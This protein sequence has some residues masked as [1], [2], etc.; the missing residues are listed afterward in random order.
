MRRNQDWNP[1]LSTLELLGTRILSACLSL[2]P[3]YGPS[4]IMNEHRHLPSGCSVPDVELKGLEKT[5][6]VAL[7]TDATGRAEKG[8][9]LGD[10]ATVG[11]SVSGGPF[12]TTPRAEGWRQER[13][14]GEAPEH[15]GWS[16]HCHSSG[17]LWQPP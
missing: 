13:L 2:L 4:I 16:H 10:G 17:L 1:D 9:A 7:M 3:R 6:A 8:E 12:K 5:P 11:V 15:P 14:C